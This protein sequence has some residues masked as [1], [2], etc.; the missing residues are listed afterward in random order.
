MNNKYYIPLSLSCAILGMLFFALYQE[1]II[2][3]YPSDKPYSSNTVVVKKEAKL[4]FWHNEKW[5]TETQDMIWHTNTG[6]NIH[7][8]INSWLTLLDAEN[9][10]DK[11][12]AVQPVLLTVAQHEAYIS[13][14]RNPFAKEANTFEKWMFIEGILRTLKE[15]GIP[16]QQVQF[17]V[18][19]APLNDPHLDFSKAWP[20]Q[21]FLQTSS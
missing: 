9:I 13:F 1:I 15:N 12:I 6:K 2:I 19:H 4:I 11:K 3:R 17:L 14:D 20:I 8:L 7:Y 5:H 10:I 16:I 18:H 21:G